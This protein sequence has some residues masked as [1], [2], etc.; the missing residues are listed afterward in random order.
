MRS[1]ILPA[2]LAVLLLALPA[3]AQ[4]ESWDI[5]G[6]DEIDVA[7]GLRVVFET[8]GEHSVT[9][10]FEKGGRDDV[11]VELKGD[12]L[13]LS[14]RDGWGWRN[15]VRATF[16]VTAPRLD[17]VKASSGASMTASA[18]DA[19]AFEIDAS[20]GSSV[21]LGGV[22]DALKIDV[23]SGA[24]I[25]ASALECTDLH[26]DAS[27]GSAVRAHARGEIRADASSGASV[28]IA[29][30]GRPIDIDKSSGASVSIE[31]QEL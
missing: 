3:G 1:H 6:F 26:V 17:A 11:E 28:T 13:A 19:E 31:P 5:R 15:R 18:I 12:R 24:S 21:T 20:S 9:A 8:A 4:T 10:H 23:S 2:S 30:G 16:H 29:G 27:S 7:E 22:C 14:R 25:D